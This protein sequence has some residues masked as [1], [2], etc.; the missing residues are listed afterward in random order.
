MLRD[1]K[2][3]TSFGHFLDSVRRVTLASS[4]WSIQLTSGTQVLEADSST[5]LEDL[6]P[7][8]ARG[9][10][11]LA[12]TFTLPEASLK[13]PQ[14]PREYDE[15]A[16]NHRRRSVEWARQTAEARE[17]HL[18]ELQSALPRSPGRFMPDESWAASAP[19]SQSLNPSFFQEVPMEEAA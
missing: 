15:A 6:H 7:F 5:P 18:E 17:S 9:R 16:Y 1:V 14:R 3:S 19:S 10:I 11:E 8:R 2:L 4:A 13:L 12:Y